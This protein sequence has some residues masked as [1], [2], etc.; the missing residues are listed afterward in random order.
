MASILIIEDDP[1]MR[2]L[3]SELVSAAGHRVL[4]AANGNEGLR[5]LE[6]GSPDLLITDIV[7]PEKNGLELL[8]KL[9]SKNCLP[10]T[11]AISGTPLEWQI[12]QTAEQLGAR[13]TLAKPFTRTEL[14]DLVEVVL[15]GD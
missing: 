2:A 11:I 13:K 4:V 6:Q 9:R 12:L 14:V 8:L 10:K 7:M 5:E 1:D 3:L 15:A